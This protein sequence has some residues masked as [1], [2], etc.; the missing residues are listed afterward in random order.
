V[1]EKEGT[2]NVEEWVCQSGC[3][4]SLIDQRN[5]CVKDSQDETSG[6][7]RFFYQ[8]REDAMKEVPQQLTDYLLTLISPPPRFGQALVLDLATVD[9]KEIATWEKNS[10]PGI[11]TRGQPDAEQS[12]E[13]LRVLRPGAHLILIAPDTEPLGFT[14][15]CN[16][17]DAGFE[18]RDSILWVREAGSFYYVPKTSRSEREAGCQMLPERSG[19]ECVDREE[20]SDGMDSPRA[21]AGRTVGRKQYR[22]K[23]NL[24]ASVIANIKQKL[25]EN[26]VDPKLVQSL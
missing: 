8:V 9:W 3:P 2:E 15:A 21:G 18:I 26:G 11:V 22:L 24:P 19:A 16:L 4:S 20:G 10:I 17:E 1:Q 25:L 5:S 23:S 6:A 7:A 13:L 14:G 12:E